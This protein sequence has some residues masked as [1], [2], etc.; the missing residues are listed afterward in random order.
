[1]RNRGVAY[2]FTA[3]QYDKFYNSVRFW[4][5]GNTL[6]SRITQLGGGWMEFT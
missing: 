6:K 1:M 5:C 3:Y 4:H 2:I